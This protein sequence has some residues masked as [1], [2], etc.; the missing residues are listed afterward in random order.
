MSVVYYKLFRLL[1]NQKLNSSTLMRQA[2]ISGNIISRLRHNE[3][4]SLET[5]ENICRV[6]NC[7]ANDILEFC[8]PRVQG[9][10]NTKRYFSQIGEIQNRRYL[11]NKFKLLD[12]I[13]KV[14]EENCSEVETVADIFSGTGAVASAFTEKNIITNDLLYSNY[15][16]NVAWFG[17]ENVRLNFLSS[18]IE[19]YNQHKNFEE[20]YMTENFSDTYF[21]KIDCSKIGFI[22]EDIEK[23]F[24][25]GIVTERERAILIASLIYAMDK[26]ANTCGHYDAWRRG[27]IFEKHLNL[28]VLNVPAKN[29]NNRCF[30]ENANGLIKH[31]KADLIYIDPPYNSRQYSD[32]Y[33][34]L[35]NVARWEKPPVYGVA[36]KPDRKNLKSDYCTLKAVD[37]FED[38]IKNCKAKYILF[39]YNN[40]AQKGNERSNARISDE[41]IFRI[42]NAKGK[43]EV[44][45]KKYKAFTTGKSNIRGNEERLFLCEVRN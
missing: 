28:P 1:E 18:L 24:L 6:L 21:S 34:L 30:N 16:C 27:I 39:S 43:V 31:I 22:R 40:M 35:E 25:S 23:K 37:A 29:K 5:I 38:L 26:I 11:G 32:T 36:L 20:N 8:S 45:S 13:K 10:Q 12:F 42:L 4:V 7:Q 14:V 41:D 33:H 44:F 19:E 15:V 3:Y 17:S 2:N 9:V